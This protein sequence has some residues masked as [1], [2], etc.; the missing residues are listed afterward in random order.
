MSTPVRSNAQGGS[1]ADAA[2]STAGAVTVTSAQPSRT[3]AA[4]PDA[5]RGVQLRD[6]AIRTS[7]LWVLVGIA[8]LGTVLYPNFLALA[9][10]NN[11]IAQVAPVGIVAL[12]MT[13]V[14]IGGGFDLSV[15]AIYAGAS[16]AYAS[17]ANHMPLVLA[18]VLT[19][20][21][22]MACG[23]FNGL[24]ITKA[25]VNPFIATIATA[26]LFSGG[27]YMYS[28]SLPV[29]VERDG[30]GELGSGQWGGAWISIYI[31]AA[32]GLVTGFVLA[33]TAHGRSVYAVGGNAEAARLAGL[34]VNAVRVS[35]YVITGACAAV[36]GMITASQIGVGQPNIGAD[37][38]L[39]SIAIVVIGGT[40]IMGGE[41]AIWRT[42]IGL[43]IWAMIT[44]LFSSLALDTGT[45]L[46]M[47]GLIVLIAVSAESL[48]RRQR[49]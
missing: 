14:I 12:A 40:S 33:R 44:N 29:Y 46:L 34:R 43:A 7:M 18:F 32:I 5:G 20:I 23:I 4:G 10:V 31:L 16:V 22:G 28:Q 35:T 41:G 11:M 25:R 37:I 9:N 47:V 17:L 42:G 38:T 24:V 19:V 49:R 6:I 8:I 45:Q 3:D 30:F 26:S 27:T 2:P 13:Y 21:L 15:T 36:A 48:S 39:N 1:G